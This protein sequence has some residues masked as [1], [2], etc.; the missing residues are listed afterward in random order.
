MVHWMLNVKIRIHIVY[1]I[2]SQRF[3]MVLSI[4]KKTLAISNVVCIT[5]KKLNKIYRIVY[6]YNAFCNYFINI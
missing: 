5:L 1:R 4:T 6:P 2:T 3:F